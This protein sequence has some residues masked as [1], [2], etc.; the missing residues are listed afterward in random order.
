MISLFL[1]VFLLSLS[2]V[3]I[4][5][6]TKLQLKSKPLDNIQSKN[7]FIRDKLTSGCCGS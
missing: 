7:T 3:D 1:F 4:D 6:Q 2:H 5:V